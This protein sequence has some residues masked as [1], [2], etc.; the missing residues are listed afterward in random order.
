MNGDQ[1]GP[2]DNFA[3]QTR[4]FAEIAET[5]EY[6][7]KEKIES[8][9]MNFRELEAY[10]DE[11]RQ[12][13]FDT[14]QLRVQYFKKF[15]VPLFAFILA[16]VSVP[17]ALR[18]GNRG[19]MAG[20]GISFVIYIAYSSV[21]QLFEQVGNLN[22]LPPEIAAWSPDAVFSLAGLYFLARVRS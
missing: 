14:T 19:A 6:F 1:F 11:L 17:F 21:Q 8:E 13:G 16:L 9:Q 3:G 4:V 18:T 20:V 5:P 12:S 2:I 22:Q 15:S 7:L 10:I